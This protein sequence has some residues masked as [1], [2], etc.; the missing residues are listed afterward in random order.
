MSVDY[1]TTFLKLNL[2]LVNNPRS[3]DLLDIKSTRIFIFI[4]HFSR[5]SKFFKLL[6]APLIFISERYLNILR[7][8]FG[9]KKKRY[10]QS[11]ALIV[12]AYISYFSKIGDE[13]YLKKAIEILKWI[14]TQRSP[15][16]K[17]FCWGQPYNWYSRKIIPKTTPRATVT[18]QVVNAFLDAYT[19]TNEK[20]YLDIAI[21]ACN[22]FIEHLKGKHVSKDEICFSYTSIDDYCIHNANMLVAAVLFRVWHITKDNKLK[23]YGARAMNYTVRNQKEDGS[24]YYWGPPD[25]IIGKIDHYHTGFVLESLWVIKEY[26]KDEFP[27][28]AE[29]SKGIEYYIFH[30]FN[31]DDLPKLTNKKTYP[32]DIQSCA[33][34]I[35]T[36]GTLSSNSS[37]YVVRANHVAKWTLENMFNKRGYFYYRKYKNGK[38]DKTPYNRWGESWMLRALTFLIENKNES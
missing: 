28:E 31:N 15:G 12:R 36:L 32:I 19:I 23:S 1:Q 35:I 37:T 9:A 34:A 3:Y 7:F 29:L 24:W 33:Q 17:Y 4:L 26:L 30:L 8:I 21:S 22:F 11:D 25:K 27:Y 5:N 13:F 20:E 18:T 16:Y 10:V 38:I 2:W 6:T 14:K